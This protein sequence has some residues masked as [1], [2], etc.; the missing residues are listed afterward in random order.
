MLDRTHDGAA[1]RLDDVAGVAFQRVT[2]RIVGGQE[3][4]ALAAL[5]D[6]CGA[7]ALGQCDSVVCVVNGVRRAFFIGQASRTGAV[8][9]ED[10]FFSLA[11]FA[12]AS[13]VPELVPPIR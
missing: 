6:D 3:E 2:E 13:A 11:T 1:R 9:N 8:F 12:I 4:P 7:C 5:L 10:L